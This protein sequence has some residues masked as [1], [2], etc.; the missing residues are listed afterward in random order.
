MIARVVDGETLAS[1]GFTHDRETR[2]RRNA[3]ITGGWLGRATVVTRKRIELVIL[4]T[5]RIVPGVA[6]Q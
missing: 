3:G 6:A 1:P 5:P 2:E 4:L